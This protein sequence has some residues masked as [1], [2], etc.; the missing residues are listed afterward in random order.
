LSGRWRGPRT[1]IQREYAK[2]LD[3]L[4][5]RYASAKAHPRHTPLKDLQTLWQFRHQLRRA[6]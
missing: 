3:I 4:G 6:M 5:W 1:S 2:D